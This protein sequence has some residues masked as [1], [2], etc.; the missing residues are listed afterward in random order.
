MAENLPGILGE[1]SPDE[2]K[3]LEDDMRA[4]YGVA[5]YAMPLGLGLGGGAMLASIA[6]AAGL[7]R[8]PSYAMGGA[9]GSS[10]MDNITRSQQRFAAE[11]MARDAE[12][13]PGGFYGRRY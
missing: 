2:R 10:L 1:L 8:L 6:R 4:R 12:G 5:E 13:Q 9:F 3:R 11:Q 7:N